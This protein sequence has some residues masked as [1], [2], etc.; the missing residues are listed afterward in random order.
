MSY[1][2]NKSGYRTDRKKTFIPTYNTRVDG[3]EIIFWEKPVV[4]CG[5]IMSQSLCIGTYIVNGGKDSPVI[6]FNPKIKWDFAVVP[7]PGGQFA[8]ETIQ[9]TPQ[10]KAQGIIECPQLSRPQAVGAGQTVSTPI[11]NAHKD[12]FGKDAVKM[13]Q[14]AQAKQ[15]I[16]VGIVFTDNVIEADMVVVGDPLLPTQV[17]GII[18][19][20]FVAIAYINPFHLMPSG[21]GGCGEW[22]AKPPCN[23]ILSNKNWQIK[24]MNHRIAEGTYTTSF[25]LY[26]ATPGFDINKGQPIGGAP[27]GA[28]I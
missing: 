7:V 6:E 18:G 15:A 3:G 13:A 19:G 21:D 8:G 10:A 22:L 26:L 2:V 28:A 16:E 14:Q 23:E 4:D 27:D 24:R 25:G 11:T 12:V 20:K 5:E 1:T 17:D 9:P